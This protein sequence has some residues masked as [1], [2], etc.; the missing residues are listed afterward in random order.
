MTEEE[1]KAQEQA[2]A[3]AQEQEQAGGEAGGEA[4][5]QNDGEG[6][7]NEGN[8]GGEQP[9]ADKAEGVD[10]GEKPAEKLPKEVLFERV[11]TSFPDDNYDE[12]EEQYYRRLTEMLDTAEGGNKKYNDFMDKLMR[13]YQDDPEEVAALMDYVE[14]M[15]LIAALTKHKGE[16]ALTMKEGDEGWDAYQSAVAGRKADRERYMALMDEVQGNI[17]STVNEINSWAEE[18]QLTDEQQAAV[19]KLINEDMDN[20]SRGK[21]TKDILNRYRMAANHDKDVDG[22]YEQGKAD[23]KNEKIAATQAKMKGSGLPGMAVA[24]APKEE[25]KELSPREQMAQRMAG[26]RRG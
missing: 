10:G 16:E 9:A 5:S 13:R 20:I 17:D 23:G 14:G 15:P 4:G 19:W 2:A 12:D 11:R 3:A 18:Q 1:K 21:F 6:A 25:K 8:D 7:G 24:S 22:A 26:W